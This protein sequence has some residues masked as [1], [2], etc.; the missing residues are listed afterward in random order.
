M[1]PVVRDG[2]IVCV[3]LDARPEEGKVPKGSIWAVKKDGGAVV[4]HIQVGEGGIVL[5][6]ANPSHPPEVV[7]DGEAIIGRVVW[8]WQAM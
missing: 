4:K 6:S 7:G 1:F 5:I 2:A 8:M 3:D